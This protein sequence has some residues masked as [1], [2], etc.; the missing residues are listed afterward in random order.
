MADEAIPSASEEQ[1]VYNLRQSR[2]RTVI[3]NTFGVLTSRWRIFNFPINAYVESIERYVKSAIMFHNYLRQADNALYCPQE[4]VNCKEMDGSS[5][6]GHWRE[7][8][9]NNGQF[10]TPLG[11]VHG[12]TYKGDAAAIRDP[13]KEYTNVHK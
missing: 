7:S 1:R 12:S 9:N 6:K 8:I 3:E 4:F 13:L 11:K 5:T 10:L 2:L